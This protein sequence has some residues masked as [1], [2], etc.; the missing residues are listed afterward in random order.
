MPIT[1]IIF[2]KTVKYG[3][4]KKLHDGLQE[5]IACELSTLGFPLKNESVDLIFEKGHRL[6]RG[7]PLKI[8][9]DG[10]DFPE[11]TRNIQK[12]SE[13]IAKKV[14]KMLSQSKGDK[15]AGFVYVTLQAGGLGKFKF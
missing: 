7:K 2:D 6:N 12:R 13:K 1:K 5:I 3:V 4:L 10:N 14:E 11:R 15:K 8:L 9:I